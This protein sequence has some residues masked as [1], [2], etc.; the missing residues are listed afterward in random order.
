MTITLLGWG[1]VVLSGRD[2][3][4]NNNNNDDTNNNSSNNNKGTKLM[5]YNNNITIIH[6]SIMSLG[7]G[8]TDKYALSLRCKATGS[9]ISP[10][11]PT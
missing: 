9:K 10:R 2:N 6:K 1:G 8:N 3:N 5:I 7:P 11:G 4:H